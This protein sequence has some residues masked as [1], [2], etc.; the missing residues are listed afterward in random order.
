MEK[1]GVLQVDMDGYRLWLIA[2][3]EGPT[4]QGPETTLGMRMSTLISPKD[5]I[6]SYL[7]TVWV[8]VCPR[9]ALYFEIFFN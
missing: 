5:R 1:E 3:I 4:A 2:S 8:P 9:T 7:V 6:Q